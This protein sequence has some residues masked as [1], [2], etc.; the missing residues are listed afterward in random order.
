MT[1]TKVFLD[2]ND[3]RWHN[4]LQRL[5]H[6][7]Y[8]LP[9]YVNVSANRIRAKATAIYIERDG[10]E[11]FIPILLRN[12]PD[13]IGKIE[14]RDAISPYGYPGPLFSSS[15]QPEMRR[16]LWA[17]MVAW[18][19]DSRIVSLFIRS[20]PLL[21]PQPGPSWLSTTVVE[22]GRIVY[23]DL[24]E[25]IR[26]I[27]QQRRSDTRRNI[28]A[29]KRSGFTIAINDWN[30]YDDFMQ[31][32][33]DTM[34]RVGADKKYMFDVEYFRNLRT[35]LG[36]RLHLCVVIAPNGDTAAGGLFFEC[37][38]IYQYH[39]G[40]TEISYLRNSPSKLMF[41]GV[42]E[43]AKERHGL[44]LVLGGGLDGEE[45]SLFH[46]KK[47]WSNHAQPYHS[48]RVVPS[49]TNYLA[50]LKAAD[51]EMNDNRSGIF[52]VYRQKEL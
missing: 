52:P 13:G 45:D 8:H 37:D 34:R 11:L 51:V 18:A 40:A 10:K 43:W 4:I 46:F 15:A 25:D 5:R 50:I 32:Y 7:I 16:E 49:E 19:Q 33:W 17:T 23:V 47:G 44:Q 2:S 48:I 36:D 6:D 26:S 30:R 35:A 41:D 38:G 21:T 24:T 27:R 3:L 29:L 28:Q 39:L 31:S 14:W 12:L 20:H 22:H 9:S 1:D 42:I